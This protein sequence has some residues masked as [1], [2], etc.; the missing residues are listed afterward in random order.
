M[1]DVVAAPDV[2]QR[3][4]FVKGRHPIGIGSGDHRDEAKGLVLSIP[5]GRRR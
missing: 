2:V 4:C 3:T 1:N 5:S